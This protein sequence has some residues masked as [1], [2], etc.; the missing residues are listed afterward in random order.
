MAVSETIT[1]KILSA[2]VFSWVSFLAHASQLMVDT[3]KR[4]ILNLKLFRAFDPPQK[5]QRVK[6][7]KFRV[8]VGHYWRTLI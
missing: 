4:E 6:Q 5:P 3:D 2:F 8:F 1:N 7:S